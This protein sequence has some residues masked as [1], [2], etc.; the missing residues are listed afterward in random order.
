MASVTAIFIHAD[1]VELKFLPSLFGLGLGL[2]KKF[3]IG[4]CYTS[5]TYL[6][7]FANSRCGWIKEYKFDLPTDNDEFQHNGERNA[8]GN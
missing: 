5:L 6:F 3:R 2:G 8:C 1:M 7:I 4:N